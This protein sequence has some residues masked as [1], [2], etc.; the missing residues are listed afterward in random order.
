MSNG[1]DATH[2]MAAR[3]QAA[4]TG[5]MEVQDTTLGRGEGFAARFRGR[6]LMDSVKAYERVA[7][8]FRALNHTALFRREG[9][10]DVILAMPGAVPS[11]FAIGLAPA[12][13]Y[14][15]RLHFSGIC[16]PRL[17]KKSSIFSSRSL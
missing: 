4:L 2:D 5:L 9:D 15:W 17:A 1:L 6:L 10:A 8:A 12:G 3:L 11:L 14:A 7:P 16:R 13:M